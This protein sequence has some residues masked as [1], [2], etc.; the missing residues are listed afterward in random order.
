MDEGVN[1]A[2][3]HSRGLHIT[4]NEKVYLIKGLFTNDSYKLLVTDFA[5]VWQENLKNKELLDRSKVRVD[6][7]HQSLFLLKVSVL[8]K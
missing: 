2:W 5:S 4:L 3:K 6:C 8:E 7:T 1:L